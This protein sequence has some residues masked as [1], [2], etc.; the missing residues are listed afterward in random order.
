[1]RARRA[2]IV[3]VAL[4]AILAAP[5]LAQWSF[6]IDTVSRYIWRGFD[7]FA[8]DNGAF[9]PSA[10]YT[11]G[12]SGLSANV[13]T[14]FAL[15]DRSIYRYDDEIDV[16]LTYVIPTSDRFD[17]SVGLIHYGWYFDRNFAL[18]TS[19][20]QELFL[21]AGWPQAPLRPS[22]SLYYDVNMGSGLYASLKVGQDIRLAEKLAVTVTA[23][24]G[25][26]SR[27]WIEGSGF[28]DL[29]LGASLPIKLG[30]VTLAPLVNW[31]IV[32]MDEV[33]PNDEIW[34]GLSI[35]L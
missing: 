23:S 10:T 7:L 13:W 17:L 29:T 30:R 12:D 22:L 3:A 25:Y 32:F 19:T 27:Q 2:P 4:L 34:F 18:K 11:F 5:A 31:T 33:N 16:T 20:T 15:G 28:S 9:Q 35:I 24:I 8:P 14:S 1:V 6:Q 26:N 21:T